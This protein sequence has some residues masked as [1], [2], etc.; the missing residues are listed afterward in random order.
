MAATV[1]VVVV[2]ILVK[3]MVWKG[4]GDRNE[5]VGVREENGV[6]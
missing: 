2:V 5:G 6:W 3:L 1:V 4:N